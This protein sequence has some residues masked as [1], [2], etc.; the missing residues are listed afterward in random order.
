M[1]DYVED[2]GLSA[3]G[4]LGAVIVVSAVIY[5]VSKKK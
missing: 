1:L 2:L 5:F 4:I 3:P